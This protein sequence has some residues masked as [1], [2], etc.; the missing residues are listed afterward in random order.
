MVNTII[1][2][3][4][5][6]LGKVSDARAANASTNLQNTLNLSFAMFHLKMPSLL[7]FRNHFSVR[8]DNLGRIYDVDELPGDVAI[9]GA[10]DIVDTKEL[11]ECFSDQVSFLAKR[12]VWKK[13][14]VLNGRFTAISSDGTQHYCSNKKGCPQCL[15]KNHRNGKTTYYHQM[16]GAVAV[17]PDSKVVLPIGCEAIINGDGGT[18][19]DC[20]LNALKRLIPQ[21]RKTFGEKEPIL[22][23]LDALY[24]NAPCIR[25]LQKNQM[26]FIIGAKG[27]HYVGIQVEKLR[28][29][30][31][32]KEIVWYDKNKRCTLKYATN[33]ILN[34]G[35]QDI[36]VNYFAL[37]EVDKV[38]GEQLFYSDWITDINLEEFDLRE[39]TRV[40]RSRWKVENETFNTLKNQGYNLEHNY[41][42][43]K[44]NLMT[45]FTVLMFLAFLVDQ[46]AMILDELFQ[47]AKKVC[48]S[49]KFLW[50][51][52][53]QVFDMVPAMSMQAIYRFI[54]KQKLLDIPPL[55]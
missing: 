17:N 8:A 13:R 54:C 9:R 42:H 7:Q 21:V 40:A 44:K 35:N 14:R 47:E 19:N 34:G 36:K 26:S 12:G 51:R 2:S 39:L 23:L 16:L 20:E 55:I 37:T 15:I 22:Q 29:E 5:Q 30:G 45:N 1:E 38:T 43:G 53:R 3:I 28:K 41:G 4:L 52:V 10:V 50:E 24:H 18:K 11:K 33:L 32:L 46:M 6:G 25:L 49:F 48:G 31:K 27:D